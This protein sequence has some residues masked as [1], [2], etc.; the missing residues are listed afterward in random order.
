[1]LSDHFALA[2]LCTRNFVILRFVFPR[3][4]FGV[5]LRLSLVIILVYT[6]DVMEDKKNW[7]PV[8]KV[9]C[10]NYQWW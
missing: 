5:N 10:K 6:F 4:F 9:P 8:D 7:K 1:M 2:T 3:I